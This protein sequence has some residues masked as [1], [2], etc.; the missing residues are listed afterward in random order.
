MLRSKAATQ[1][2]QE[3]GYRV[4]HHGDIL[5]R[6]AYVVI[7]GRGRSSS[8]RLLNTEEESGQGMSQWQWSD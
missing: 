6:W 1:Y 8:M 2:C 5:A 4:G 3:E 7:K